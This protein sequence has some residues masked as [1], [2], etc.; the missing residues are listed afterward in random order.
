MEGCKIAEGLYNNPKEVRIANLGSAINSAENDFSPL[1]TQDEKMMVFTS[2]REGSTGGKKT[3]NDEYFEDIYLTYR[4]NDSLWTKPQNISRNV[5]S[6]FHDAAAALSPDG[7]RLFIYLDEGGGD[8][9]MSEFDGLNWSKPKTLGPHV[10]SRYWETSVTIT[11]DGRKIYFASS[12]PGGYG[13]LDIYLSMLQADGQWGPAENLGPTINTA[14]DEDA[15]FVHPDGQTL[16]FSSNGHP[17][18]G[19]FDIFKSELVDGEWAGAENFGYPVNTTDDDIHFVMTGNRKKAYFTSVKEDGIGKA[20]IYALT[21]PYNTSKPPLQEEQIVI[22]EPIEEGGKTVLS[23]NVADHSKEV[24]LS[25]TVSLTNNENAELVAEDTTDPET[26]DFELI[27]YGL[28]SFALNIE[29]QGF[30]FYSQNLKITQEDQQ[31]EKKEI[32]VDVRMRPMGVGST[33]ILS[34]IFFNTGEFILRSE[35]Y[36]ELEKILKYLENSPKL[37]VQVNGHTDNVGEAS[38]NKTLSRKRAEAVKD[39]LIKGGIGEDRLR[40]KGFGE[41]RP[42]VSN[43]DEFEGRELNRRT[44]IEVTAF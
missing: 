17:G 29:A 34:N 36:P 28:G 23:G 40:A 32:N 4:L 35:S 39:Y 1:I 38:Y 13:K 26:G 31:K 24:P 10:N 27:V 22:K 18:L 20:D 12:R 41:E 5:N 25:A 9:F 16:Y 33:V 30:L 7:K 14:E 44:E 15:P 6:A 8:L 42:L 19:G 11:A 3:G 21:F 43:D 2:R 37:K